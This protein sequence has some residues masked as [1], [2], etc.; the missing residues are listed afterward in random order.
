MKKRR[1][2]INVS[3]ELLAKALHLREGV[4]VIRARVDFATGTF[5]FM[6]SGPDLPECPEG[7]EAMRVRHAAVSEFDS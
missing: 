6:L 4:E 2:L 1:A 7:Q 5:Q 3:P